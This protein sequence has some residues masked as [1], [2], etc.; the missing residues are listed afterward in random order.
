MPSLYEAGWRQGS[1]FVGTLPF[2]AVVVDAAGQVVR[3][4]GEHSR[5]AVATQECDLDL[6]EPDDTQPTIELRAVHVDDPPQDWGLRSWRFRL[7]ESHHVVS[8]DPRL[9][10]SAA[11]L[12]AVLAAGAERLNP[13]VT[14]SRAFAIWLG[15]R[16]DRPALPPELVP[17]AKRIADEVLRRQGRVVAARVRD[18][19]MSFDESTD[20]IRYSLFAVLEDEVDE[21]PVREWLAGIAARVPPELGI[22]DQFEAAPAERISLQL[23]EQSYAADVRRLTW[24]QNDPEPTGA[25]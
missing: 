8:Q 19:L 10:V 25:E 18:V 11:V 12:T 9:S 14:R 1:I 5:W 23:I 16:Y 21:E 24:R 17:L 15:L 13:T 7:T 20:P 6:T 4:Q 22:A 3:Q 2:D